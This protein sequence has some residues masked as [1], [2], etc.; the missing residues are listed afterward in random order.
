MTGFIPHRWTAW[1]SRRG[2]RRLAYWLAHLS[3]PPTD[4]AHLLMRPEPGDECAAWTKSPHVERDC[5]GDGHYLCGTCRRM[6]RGE[7]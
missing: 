6:K 3:P 1:L 4:R 7:R 5:Q 2:W